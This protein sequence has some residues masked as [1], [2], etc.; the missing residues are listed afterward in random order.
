MPKTRVC[1]SKIKYQVQGQLNILKRN[2]CDFVI[3]TKNDFQ[4]E[5]I[6]KHTEVWRTTMLPKLNSFYQQCMLPEIVDGRIPR[7]MKARD[8]QQCML[9]EIV[10]GRIPR[11]MKVN[12]FYQQCML[13]EIVDGRIPRGMKARDPKCLG[14][15]QEEQ[16]L[17]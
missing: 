15:F 17:V 10:D 11:G 13:P 5:R 4:V 1:P 8:Y 12:S 6:Y 2:F 7:G 14:K 9:P 3:Y 16:P